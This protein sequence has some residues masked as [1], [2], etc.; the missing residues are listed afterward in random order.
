MR[1]G[2]GEAAGMGTGRSGMKRIKGCMDGEDRG[3]RDEGVREAEGAQ[4]WRREEAE[5]RPGWGQQGAEGWRGCGDES[6]ET[7]GC[8]QGGQQPRAALTSTSS[9]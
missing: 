1:L 2:G 5:R 8:G 6:V 9:P 7:E 3:W 4:E